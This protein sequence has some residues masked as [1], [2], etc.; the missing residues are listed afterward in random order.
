VI[1]GAGFGGLAVVHA[2][3]KAP[4]DIVLIDRSNHHLFQPLLYQV[5]S[6]L[7]SP[8][9]IAMPIRRLLAHLPHVTVI[10]GDVTGVD[11]E[12]QC[13]NAMV[14]NRTEH[15]DYDYL[16]LATGARHTYFA[17]EHWEAVAPG[18]KTIEDA[19][20]IRNRLLTAFEHAEMAQD[21][22]EVRRLL[23]IAVVGAGP[24]GVEMAGTIAELAHA[25]LSKE[26]RRINPAQTRV[27]LIEGGPRVLATFPEDLSLAAQES[28]KKLRVEVMLGAPVTDCT[29][30]KIVVGEQE[31]PVGNIIWA[32]GVKASPAASWL[33]VESDRAGRVMV[34]AD[35]RVP[36][37][38]NIFVIG[39]TAIQ[40]DARG[41]MVPGVA[42]GAIQ[43]G[44]HVG[45][46][47]LSAITGK[48][49]PKPFCYRNMG[50]MAT[51]GRHAAV[52]DFGW[53]KMKGGLAWW[54]WGGVHIA[55]LIGF[56][57]RVAVMIHWLWSFLT[58]KRGVCLISKPK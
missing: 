35:F 45:K 8:A 36:G 5:A 2:L 20:G 48:P 26:F 28:L 16:V 37:H 12:N 52:A 1:V 33:G 43:G 53:M 14:G 21:P 18:L 25:A 31:I 46:Q 32:A 22:D 58:Y 54:L 10:M 50:N 23:T 27:I 39:D 17:N 4:I 30:E 40:T 19:Q 29:A 11:H 41:K 24:T 51:I 56:R 55:F 15:F 3:Q 44:E 6:A 7:L 9:E 57:N 38:K 42:Q 13:V 34:E 49:A 47:I